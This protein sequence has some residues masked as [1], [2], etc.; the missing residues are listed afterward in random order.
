MKNE[1]EEFK[2]LERERQR[3]EI[4]DTV[5]KG[6][7]ESGIADVNKCASFRHSE[8]PYGLDMQI[9]IQYSLLT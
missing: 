3:Q 8:N 4:I 9:L 2:Q 6:R 5:C 7:D 1:K